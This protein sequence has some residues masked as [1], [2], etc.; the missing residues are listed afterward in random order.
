MFEFSKGFWSR[1]TG[2][3]KEDFFT[4]LTDRRDKSALS[5]ISDLE[6]SVHPGD[7]LSHGSTSVSP[8]KAV[9][10]QSKYTAMYDEVTRLETKIKK[11]TRS[12][13]CKM[14]RF[15]CG[16][17][18]LARKSGPDSTKYIVHPFDDYGWLDQFRA[19][20]ITKEGIA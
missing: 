7:T 3:T 15:L 5:L 9:I 6:A 11:L 14:D 13:Q 17:R 2:P 18:F 1:L 16:Y 8:K 19:T 10:N 4:L 20:P 12:S